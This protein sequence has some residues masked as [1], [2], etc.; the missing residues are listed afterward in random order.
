MYPR[1]AHKYIGLL[2]QPSEHKSYHT[3]RPRIDPFA[4]V[5]P[6]IAAQLKMPR[7]KANTIFEQLQLRYSGWFPEG[8]L[9]I[10]PRKIKHWRITEG[11]SPEIIFPRKHKPVDIC[12]SDFTNMNGMGIT[13]DHQPF[14]HIICHFVLTGT[15]TYPTS[16]QYAL[17][18]YKFLVFIP[19]L[20]TI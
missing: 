7:L 1:T 15:T 12:A 2:V 11:E 3:W 18:Y 6:E 14:L 5:W 19:V 17:P 9:R 16:P 10:L 13:I 4:D 20:L 8:Q